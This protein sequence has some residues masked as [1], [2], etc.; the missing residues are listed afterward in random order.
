MASIILKP[1]IRKFNVIVLQ[2]TH[3]IRYKGLPSSSSYIQPFFFIGVCQL[4]A[5]SLKNAKRLE[6]KPRA[7]SSSCLIVDE[8]LSMSLVVFLIA[9]G[10]M[11]VWP[12]TGRSREDSCWQ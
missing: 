3:R 8:R 7:C 12:A 6:E 4:L 11:L 9:P 10:Q 2:S 1:S 5:L